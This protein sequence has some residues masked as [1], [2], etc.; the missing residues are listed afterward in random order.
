MFSPRLRNLTKVLYPIA[1]VNI[2][3][4]QVVLVSKRGDII[5]LNGDLDVSN[6]LSCDDEGDR[7]LRSFSYPRARCTF[8]PNDIPTLGE[9]LVLFLVRR[10]AI[11]VRVLCLDQGDGVT[12]TASVELTSDTVSCIGQK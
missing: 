2:H 5:T 10:D 9:V 4:T 8:L 11:Y 12:H 7:F 1:N 3:P 6:E